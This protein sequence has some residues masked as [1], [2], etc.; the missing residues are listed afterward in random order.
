MD[1]MHST[2]S[3]AKNPVTHLQKAATTS[4]TAF[5]QVVE[6]HLQQIGLYLEGLVSCWSDTHH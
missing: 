2:S 6:W 1:S 5:S 4:E 3:K